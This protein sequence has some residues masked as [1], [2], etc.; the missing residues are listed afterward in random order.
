MCAANVFC[1]VCVRACRVVFVMGCDYGVAFRRRVVQFYLSHRPSWSLSDVAKK[2]EIPGGKTTVW[3]WVAQHG[4]L[5]TRK[6]S[7]RPALLNARQ[8]NK[9][10]ADKIRAANRKHTAIDYKEVQHSIYRYTRVRPSLPTIRR[11][12]YNAL[13]ARSKRTV[14]RTANQCIYA[15]MHPHSDDCSLCVC[16]VC[17]CLCACVVLV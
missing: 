14:K 4:A 6:R 11:Y 13:H 17:V 5:E 1:I 16:C 2:F 9:H 7:G 10:V 15:H 12:G 3:R 8:I